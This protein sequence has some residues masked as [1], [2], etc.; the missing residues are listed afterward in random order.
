MRLGHAKSSAYT[1][2]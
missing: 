1:T 2:L